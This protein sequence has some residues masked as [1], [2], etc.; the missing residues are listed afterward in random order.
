MASQISS[1][2]VFGSGLGVFMIVVQIIS[3]IVSMILTN[4]IFIN[5]GLMY[6]DSRTDL[7]RREDLNEIE[8]IG[9][10]EI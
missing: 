4:A 7:H 1:G 8:T 3:M 2:D 6:Y 10:R 9:Q 5:S